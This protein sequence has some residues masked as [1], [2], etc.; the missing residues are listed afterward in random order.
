MKKKFLVSLLVVAALLGLYWGLGGLDAAHPAPPGLDTGDSPAGVSD[1][2][3]WCLALAAATNLVSLGEDEAVL[4]HQ[5]RHRTSSWWTRVMPPVADEAEAWDRV[6]GLLARHDGLFAHLAAH[7]H[8]T[9]WRYPPSAFEQPETPFLVRSGFSLSSAAVDLFGLK[10]ERE[11]AHDDLAAAL[12]DLSTLESLCAAAQKGALS[13]A[14]WCLCKTVWNRSCGRLLARV[15]DLDAAQLALLQGLVDSAARDVEVSG[16][17]AYARGVQLLEARWNWLFRR[18]GFAVLMAQLTK[19][20]DL[21]AKALH[22]V[23]ER[24]RLML[25]PKA[26]RTVAAQP[27][28]PAKDPSAWRPPVSRFSFHFN[29]SLAAVYD[30]SC[31]THACLLHGRYD[32]SLRALDERLREPEG[33]LRYVS[34]LLPN[35]VGRLAVRTARTERV[36]SCSMQAKE[37]FS[38]AAARVIVAANRFRRATGAYPLALG[39]LVPDYLPAV[40]RD[41]FGDGPIGY[42]VQQRTL[43]SVGEAGSFDGVLPPNGVRGLYYVDKAGVRHWQNWAIRRLDGRPLGESQ[44]PNP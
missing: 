38:L 35:A 27:A 16:A 22:E 11:L 13:L 1:D 14:D 12:R 44:P 18:D 24:N 15:A 26:A 19:L 32:M 28:A 20:G 36:T 34:P 8:C 9:G 17:Q 40:P 2:D 7:A 33:W 3:N 4:V 10:I 37:I 29:R 39:E 5:A 6:D 25:D 31:L 42:N 30:E 21:A 43:H 23:A 41:P